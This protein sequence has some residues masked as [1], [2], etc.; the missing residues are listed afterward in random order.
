VAHTVAR[1]N[2]PQAIADNGWEERATVQYVMFFFSP[3]YNSGT[4][5][6]RSEA[7]ASSGDSGGVDHHARDATC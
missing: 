7:P 6:A 2:E 4:V 1:S 3:F 5:R